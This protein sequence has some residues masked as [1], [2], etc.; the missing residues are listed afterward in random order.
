MASD[1]I[2]KQINDLVDVKFKK[3]LEARRKEHPRA[4]ITVAEECD[5][6]Q[7]LIEVEYAERGISRPPVAP[8]QVQTLESFIA[9]DFPLKEGLIT[10]HLQPAGYGGASGQA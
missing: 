9:R 6:R 2:Q 8:V 10:G 4:V 1:D 5:L 7:R 3:G